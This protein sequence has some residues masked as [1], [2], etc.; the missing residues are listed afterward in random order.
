MKRSLAIWTTLV[1][2]EAIPGT[3]PARSILVI[4][5][6]VDIVADAGTMLKGS[7]TVEFPMPKRSIANVHNP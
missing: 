2:D 3:V 4:S 7:A 5:Y 6:M 1:K